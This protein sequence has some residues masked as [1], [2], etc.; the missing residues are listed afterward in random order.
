MPLALVVEDD[1]GLCTIYDRLLR[2]MD[3]DVLEASDGKIALD[4]LENHSPNVVF[5][6]ILL[7]RVNGLV[8]LDYIQN[9]PHLQNA[10]VVVVT[11][12]RRFEKDVRELASVDFILKPIRPAQIT[13]IAK[14]FSQV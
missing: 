7:P 1:K 12:N 5:L 10:H 13:D 3:Y 2:G 8:V 4:I 6:D 11:S 9:A 14:R